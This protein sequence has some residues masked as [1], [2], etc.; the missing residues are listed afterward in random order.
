MTTAR[1]AL[2]RRTAI[3]LFEVV[4]AMAIFTLTLPALVALVQIGARRAVESSQLARASM[5]CRSKLAE[6]TVGAEALDGTDWTP[7]LDANWYWKLEVSGGAV[8]GLNQVQVSVKF[9]DG[10]NPVR[11]TL[12]QMVIDPANRG[13]TQDRAILSSL[14]NSAGGSG[15]SS[16]ADPAATT[17]S[18]GTTAAGATA[19]PTTGTGATAAPAAGATRGGGGS[20]TGTGGGSGSGTGMSGGASGAGGSYGG[21]K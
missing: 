16:A 18:T 8:D 6:V 5:E 15:S 10:A 17:G 7:L 13:S 11:V 19:A 21:S 20:G 12:S 2:V 3:T 14:A 1:H 9:D 4:V